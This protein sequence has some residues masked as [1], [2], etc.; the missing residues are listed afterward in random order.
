[1]ALGGG[2]GPG[3]GVSQGSAPHPP[4]GSPSGHPDHSITAAFMMTTIVA[5]PGPS[6]QRTRCGRSQR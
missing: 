4:E 2:L 3:P 5:R 6:V 1:M